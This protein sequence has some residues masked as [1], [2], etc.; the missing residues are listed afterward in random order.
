MKRQTFFYTI[1]VVTLA[2]AS[3]ITMGVSAS[4]PSTQDVIN[5]KIPTI[6]AGLATGADR[7]SGASVNG[8]D[9][10]VKIHGKTPSDLAVSRW[11]G[12]VL[13]RELVKELADQSYTS[14]TSMSYRDGAGDV[15][16][17]ADKV[18][19]L[20]LANP[21]PDGTCKK[22]GSADAV[23]AVMTVKATDVNALS[24]GCEFVVTPNGDTATFVKN[25][26]FKLS[27]LVSQIPESQAHPYL[28]D[29]VDQSGISHLV[30][31]WIPGVD[32]NPGQG[33]GWLPPGEQSSAILGSMDGVGAT[34]D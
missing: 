29:V 3:F 4:K 13:A 34:A 33:I 18:T 5:S 22:A 6:Q 32:G 8:S 24:G 11:Y 12:K 26:A 1:S 15:N 25:A 16:G 2:T 10:Q 20:P 21:L 9:L 7:V 23:S 17:G 31:G 14:L 28:V 30:I 19:E 27:V